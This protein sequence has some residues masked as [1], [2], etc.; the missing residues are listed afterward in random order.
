MTNI[1]VDVP[2]YE[3]A[4][5]TLRALPGVSVDVCDPIVEARVKR[6]TTLLADKDVLLCGVPPA[7]LD[8]MS[9]LRWIQIASSGFEHLVP[10]HLP[11]RGIR[12]SNARG[13]FDI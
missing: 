9:R 4:L 5:E 2:V 10:L 13:V 8:D 3:P 6:P 12:A 7:N 11:T 1:L